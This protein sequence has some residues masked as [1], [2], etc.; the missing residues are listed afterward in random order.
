V[1]WTEGV[2]DECPSAEAGADE[3]DEVVQDGVRV[4]RV[5][6]GNLV[7]TQEDALQGAEE[8]DR[9]PG[10]YGVGSGLTFP[11][12]E[13]NCSRMPISRPRV[14]VSRLEKLTMRPS[15]SP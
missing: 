8:G 13:N 9:G 12:L 5:R 1:P 15:S 11:M 3:G 10:D 2:I 7:A 4:Q 14:G 6:R